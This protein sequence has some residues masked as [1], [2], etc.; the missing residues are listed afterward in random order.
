MSNAQTVQAMYEAFGRGDVPAILDEL[1]E[2]VV[3]E[4][5]GSTT[6]VPWMQTRAGRDGARAFFEN[7]AALDFHKFDVTSVT[8]IGGRVLSV[9]DVEATVKATG[10]RFAEP[11]EVH[12]WWFNDAGKVTA[13]RH[14][15]DTHLQWKAFHAAG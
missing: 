6:D 11:D 2:N 4:V 5:A 10:E 9:V 3:W 8:D 13:F 12:I 15:A 1:D 14:R 7:L